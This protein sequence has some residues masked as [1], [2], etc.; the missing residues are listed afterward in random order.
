MTRMILK[1]LIAGLVLTA[2][3]STL[4]IAVDPKPSNETTAAPLPTTYA[5]LVTHQSAGTTALSESSTQL[6]ERIIVDSKSNVMGAFESRESYNPLAD[7][8]YTDLDDDFLDQSESSQTEAYVFDPETDA[9]S[10]A[11]VGDGISGIE[12]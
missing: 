6:Y 3:A 12:W 9:E 5:Q 8:N 2:S 7:E 11:D 10:A 1:S 4:A